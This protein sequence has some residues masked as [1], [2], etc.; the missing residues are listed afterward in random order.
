M[1]WIGSG[2]LWLGSG[3]L[4]VLV[5]ACGGNVTLFSGGDGAGGA[6]ATT[7]T[8]TTSGTTTSNTTT[9][10][11]GSGGAGGCDGGPADDQDG[12]GFTP[13]AGDC[14]DCDPQVNPAAVELVPGVDDDCDGQVDVPEPP[15]DGAFGLDDPSPDHAARAIE[16]CQSTTQQSSLPGV[17]TAAYVRSNGAPAVPA[18]QAGLLADFGAVTVP[19]FGARMLGLSTGHARDATDPGTCGQQNCNGLGNGT[20]P[21][22]FP[23]A[24]PNCPVPATIADD[25]GLELT[26][27]APSNAGGYAFDFDYHTF[28]TAYPPCS[29]WLDQFVAL[30]VP[31]PPGAINGNIVF[32]AST[33]PPCADWTGFQV[34][35]TCPLGAGDL[36]GTGFDTWAQSA[37]ATGWYTTTAPVAPSSV[38]TLRFAVWDGED[39][40]FDSTVLVDAFRWLA[41]PAVVDT[42]IAAP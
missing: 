27:R 41:A 24:A 8:T 20:A 29:Q 16:L 14:N 22:G 25:V 40:V 12:D 35:G 33:L 31:P 38:F 3:A 18:L 26:L 36:L 32:D 7:T 39:G 15:C 5:G 11:T 19:R 23:Q 34:C 28:E 1:R 2:R 42:S 17:I 21:A 30:V 9:S 37:S 10:T 4:V 13:A 6:G